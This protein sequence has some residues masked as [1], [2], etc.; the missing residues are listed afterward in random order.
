VNPA[1]TLHQG[2][3]DSA[4]QM[5]AAAPIGPKTTLY[6]VMA[7]LQSGVEPDE[8][9]LVVAIVVRWLRTGRITLVRAATAAA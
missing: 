6:D 2:R 1:M 9:D 3:K 5:A 7:V 4:R 8:V